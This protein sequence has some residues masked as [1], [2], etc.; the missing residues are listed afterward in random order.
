MVNALLRHGKEGDFVLYAQ[1]MGGGRQLV[2][3]NMLVIMIVIDLRA[4]VRFGHCTPLEN[5]PSVSL[6]EMFTIL[7]RTCQLLDQD[8]GWLSS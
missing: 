7:T 8:V 4:G 1:G 3:K 5:K 2:G 6:L